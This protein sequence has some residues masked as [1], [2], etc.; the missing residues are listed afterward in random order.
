[1]QGEY[2]AIKFNLCLIE[3]GQSKHIMILLPPITSMNI[4]THSHNFCLLSFHHVIK[5]I[6]VELKI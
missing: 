1:M 6:G 4:R 5:Y 2:E 3:N